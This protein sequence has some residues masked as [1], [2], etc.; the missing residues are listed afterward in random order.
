[1]TLLGLWSEFIGHFASMKYQSG[2]QYFTPADGDT[3]CSTSKGATL[4]VI[5]NLDGNQEL[6]TPKITYVLSTVIVSNEHNA[7]PS[8]KQ[9]TNYEIVVPVDGNTAKNLSE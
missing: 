9:N 8:K 6:E 3:L 7:N 1:M 4:S 5:P 2:F